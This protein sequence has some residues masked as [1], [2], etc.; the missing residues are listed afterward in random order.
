MIDSAERFKPD[1][2]ENNDESDDEIVDV[3][4]TIGEPFAVA[5]DENIAAAIAVDDDVANADGCIIGLNVLFVKPNV[6]EC[7]VDVIARLRL[8]PLNIAFTSE[9]NFGGSVSARNDLQRRSA[10]RFVII[11][12]R[13][14]DTGIAPARL[15]NSNC[16]GV[17]C[18][19]LKFFNNVFDI[20]AKHNRIPYNIT[21]R[22]SLPTVLTNGPDPTCIGGD[23]DADEDADD[24]D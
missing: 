17:H 3:L 5:T 24:S 10:S 11:P 7:N 1:D 14:D 19:Q 18:T 12:Q 21:L 23:T 13:R 15:N 16:T 9:S 8:P 20:C 4:V 22:T 6:N 2:E